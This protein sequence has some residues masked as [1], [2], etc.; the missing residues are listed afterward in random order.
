MQRSHQKKVTQEERSENSLLCRCLHE[1]FKNHNKK[2]DK[3]RSHTVPNFEPDHSVTFALMTE[4]L[5][6]SRAKIAIR[7]LFQLKSKNHPIAAK[8]TMDNSEIGTGKYNHEV[9]K[10]IITAMSFL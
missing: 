8:V 7:K 5:Q 1:H 10:L 6:L 3:V 4:I 2:I 9:W